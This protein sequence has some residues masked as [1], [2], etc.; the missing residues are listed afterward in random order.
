MRIKPLLFCS[1]LFFLM[2]IT[3]LFADASAEVILLHADNFE[4]INFDKVNAN[5]HLFHEQK[6]HIEVDHSASILMKAFDQ[7]R[8]VSRVSFEWRSNGRPKIKNAE[9]EERRSGDDAVFKLGLLLKADVALFNPRLPPWMQRVES[10]LTFPSG[11]VIF[12][13]VGAKHAAGEQWPNPYN[14]RVT[15]I[16]IES[17]NDSQSWRQS[18]YQF[19]KPVDVVAIW[20]VSDGDNTGSSF[21]TVIKNITIE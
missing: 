17:S 13:V 21:T 4:H 9:H 3:T 19:A 15:M 8:P 20:L 10:L 5:H 12:L 1:Q 2:Q 18:S 6:L 14:R 7:V 11:R 16:A